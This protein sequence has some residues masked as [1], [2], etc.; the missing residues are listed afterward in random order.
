MKKI[1]IAQIGIGH[2]HANAIFD[3]LN[4][5]TDVFDV[6]GYAEVEEDNLPYDWSKTN[7]IN[8]LLFISVLI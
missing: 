8:C 7:K 5:L 3:A 1:K 6:V 4:R 2:D